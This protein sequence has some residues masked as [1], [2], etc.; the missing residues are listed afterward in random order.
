MFSN[1]PKESRGV[2]R[3][4]RPSDGASMSHRNRTS[5][6]RILLAAALGVLAFVALPA[7]ASAKDRNHDRIPDRWEKRHRLS[8]KVNQARRDQDGDH[9]RNL[10]EF[11]A[12]TNP[13]D[14][15]SDND[16]VNDNEE[17]AGTIASFDAT[18]GTLTIDLFSGGQVSG[19]VNDSTEIKCGE[20]ENGGENNGSEENSGS[21]ENSGP[22]NVS[23]DDEG[24][25]SNE[26]QG[27]EPDDPQAEQEQGEDPDDPAGEENGSEQSGSEENE[28]EEQNSSCTTDALTQGTTVHEA[29]LDDSGTTFTEI[30][31]RD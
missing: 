8:L 23:G 19:L 26:Q 10:A 9:L 11:K 6:I 3:C 17:N 24:S 28:S 15:D 2:K 18:S 25:G 21:S 1:R 7:V 27:E 22:G 16:G 29:E 4:H 20:N 14:K 30:K 31:L 13:R 12:G 5:S